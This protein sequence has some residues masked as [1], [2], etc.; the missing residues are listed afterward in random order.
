MDATKDALGRVS[1]VMQHEMQ[2]II[3]KAIY[4][5]QDIVLTTEKRRELD[6]EHVILQVGRHKFYVRLAD[7][8][9]INR[10]N[11]PLA[12][13]LSTMNDHLFRSFPPWKIRL[14]L[15]YKTSGPMFKLSMTA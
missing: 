15:N 5:L 4:T 2:A 6:R 3:E 7:T 9:S 1:Q 12:S 10:W 14:R 11:Q 13:L 8:L